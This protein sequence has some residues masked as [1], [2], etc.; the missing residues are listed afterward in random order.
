MFGFDVTM[1][2]LFVLGTLCA[3]GIAW[4]FLY[5]L[6]SGDAEGEKRVAKYSSAEKIGRKGATVNRRDVLTEKMQN[7]AKTEKYKQNKTQKKSA[8]LSLKIER[9][10]LK[11]SQR[12]FLLISIT[13]G[14]AT[15]AGVML[16]DLPIYVAA[17]A[18]FV[19]GFGLPR[20]YIGFKTKKRLKIFLDEF[21]NTV[22]VIVRG[23]KAGLPLNDCLK[24]IARESPA[25][26][27]RDEFT[28]I[29]ETQKLGVPM[30]EAI[31]GLY[32]RVP[33]QEA[34]FFA[35]VIAIQQKAGGALSEALANLS[36]VLRDRKKMQGKVK[37]VSQEA[38]A[39]AAIIGSLPLVVMLLV[40]LSSPD[41]IL[42]LFQTTIGN[43]L[44]MGCAFWMFIG[45]MVMRKMINFDI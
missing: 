32:D 33:V 11:W 16:A 27:V 40:Y 12:Q 38:K 35:T 7:R 10:G 9:A 23:V 2:A 13:V 15:V 17:G 21:P 39:S 25:L 19:G 20:W 8:P 34:N 43:A 42:L 36:A 22:D 24:I 41:Y 18:G 28:K 29:I 30:G 45:V 4:V 5:P 3:G 44:L 6:L 26:P 14:L 1:F 31:A 37:A